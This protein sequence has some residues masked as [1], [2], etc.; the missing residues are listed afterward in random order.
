MLAMD[1]FYQ[2]GLCVEAFFD[3]VAHK[4]TDGTGTN[5]GGENGAEQK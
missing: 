4:S 2:C 5:G 1:V 3:R